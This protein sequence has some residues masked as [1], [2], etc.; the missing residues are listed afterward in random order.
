MKVN[1][2]LLFALAGM[3][4]HCLVLTMI[5]IAILMSDSEVY[6][7]NLFIQAQ[8]FTLYMWIAL[9][10]LVVVLSRDRE[11]Y[12]MYLCSFLV[13]VIFNW[14][15]EDS[16]DRDLFTA[17]ANQT[18]QAVVRF[19]ISKAFAPI[20]IP[21]FEPDDAETSGEAALPRGAIPHPPSAKAD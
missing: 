3:G 10:I 2:R 13:S 14:F 4:Y 12:Y 6:V 20:K 5:L 15:S 17:V 11:M 8:H 21:T 16:Y 9:N 19:M 18:G 1:L 7:W